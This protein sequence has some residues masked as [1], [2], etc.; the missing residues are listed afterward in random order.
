MGVRRL[1]AGAAVTTAALAAVAPAA[2]GRTLGSAAWP[3]DATEVACPWIDDL[4]GY[5]AEE[6]SSW[7]IPNRGVLTSWSTNVATA[8]L[9]SS[10]SMVVVRR[11]G[12]DLTIA[13]VDTAALPA[14]L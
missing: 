12:T 5:Q 10:A 4:V 7:T 9:T 8:D 1:A 2:Q 11:S 6:G 3:L 14:A 13:A